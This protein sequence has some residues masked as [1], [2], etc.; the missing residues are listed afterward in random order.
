VYGSVPRNWRVI[1]EAEPLQLRE[2]YRVS[3]TGA[4]TFFELRSFDGVAYVVS[5]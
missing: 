1:H 4:D 3:P 5:E 2:R